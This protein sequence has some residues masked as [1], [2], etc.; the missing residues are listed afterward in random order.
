MADNENKFNKGGRALRF[1]AA[2]V[3]LVAELSR[4]LGNE[5]DFRGGLPTDIDER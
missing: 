4:R 1:Q 3:D 5:I 2:R